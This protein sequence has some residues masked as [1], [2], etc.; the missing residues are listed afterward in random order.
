[1]ITTGMTFH[2]KDLAVIV[3]EI[4]APYEL[5][6]ASCTVVWFDQ[7]FDINGMEKKLRAINR[8]QARGRP[9]CVH[10]RSL[11]ATTRQQ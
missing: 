10:N 6:Y 2:G 5:P 3:T 7:V 8:S 1:M 11:A 4:Q 9:C